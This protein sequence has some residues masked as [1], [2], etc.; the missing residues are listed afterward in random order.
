MLEQRFIGAV[1]KG[2]YR[3]MERK[4]AQQVS[5]VKIFFYW[6]LISRVFIILAL[7]LTPIRFHPHHQLQDLGIL[8]AA[9]WIKLLFLTNKMVFV[10]FFLIH[11]LFPSSFFW[12]MKS[13]VGW[14]QK[15]RELK[16][17]VS[18]MMERPWL[19]FDNGE[20]SLSWHGSN[21]QMLHIYIQHAHAKTCI[22]FYFTSFLAW[23]KNM[24]YWVLS[25]Y[26]HIF[27]QTL[28]DI[29]IFFGILSSVWQRCWYRVAQVICFPM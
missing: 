20:N 19:V 27:L 23:W 18:K 7:C 25:I 10:L 21:W 26:F 28:G 11:Y 17:D 6:W 13:R 22:I 2:R 9:S 15:G 14:V 16:W 24:H 1:D 3:L 8:K 12:E 29:S 5:C 4:Q